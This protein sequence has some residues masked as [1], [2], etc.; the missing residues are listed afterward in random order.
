MKKSF[1]GALVV[2]LS[3]SS[4]QVGA[5]ESNNKGYLKNILDNN[6][7][8]INSAEVETKYDKGKNVPRFIEGDLSK[9]SI[10]DKDQALKYLNDNMDAFNLTKGSFKFV[11]EENEE[12][13][14]HFKFQYV[15]NGID[16][17]GSEIIIHTNKDNKVYAINGQAEPNIPNKD[18]SKDF[19]VS[20]EQAINSAYKS[21]GIKKESPINPKVNKYIKEVSGKW[22]AVYNM[23]LLKKLKPYDITI[24]AENGD[25]LE[26]NILA[27]NIHSEGEG[28]DLDGN[29]RKLNLD[30]ENGMYYLRDISNKGDVETSYGDKS[31]ELLTTLMSASSYEEYSKIIESIP[32]E[33]SNTNKFYNKDKAA[34][35]DAHSNLS[36]V[37][38]YYKDT[39]GREG[40]DD[41]GGKIKAVADIG[42][43]L[44]NAISM[45]VKKEG[46]TAYLI[47]GHTS[48]GEKNY[49]RALDVIAHEYTHSMIATTSK[50]YYSDE[51]GALNESFA[52]IFG[53]FIEGD[54]EDWDIGEDIY[55]NNNG[56]AIRCLDNPSKYGDA[57][58]IEEYYA[59]VVDN[60]GVH[61]NSTIHSKA[62]V[63]IIKEIGV[64][65]AEQ[66]Y[67]RALTKYLFSNSTFL[68][69]KYAVKQAAKDIV[70][71]K[72]EN[73]IEKAYDDVG[74]KEVEISAKVLAEPKVDISEDF[75]L[76][77]IGINVNSGN[78]DVN[79]IVDKDNAANRILIDEISIDK[80][81]NIKINN[82][83]DEKI[84]TRKEA[85]VK[86]LEFK[87]KKVGEYLYYITVQ[88]GNRH[89]R[90][91][92]DSLVIDNLNDIADVWNEN[93]EYK[94]EELVVYK[95]NVYTCLKDHS[96][97]SSWTP[98]V[99][100]S[101]WQKV[102]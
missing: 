3:L 4:I 85:Y 17:F 21:M 7:R 50:L 89:I 29:T 15:L 44:D 10:K 61:L 83:L 73:I 59:G 74:I 69:A 23:T 16:V 71:D 27:E 40:F 86:K 62:L 39:F 65:D 47:F 55:L 53:Y 96:S 87:N 28:I 20:E 1:I 67:Y 25:I 22:K 77:D 101:L 92:K 94:E 80:N 2:I 97:Q 41:K 45:P 51:S 42:K 81:G 102:F 93:K 70:G 60:G 34:T 49:A 68:D 35:I 72:Y 37:V 30:F 43:E 82:I 66:I 56:K 88:N 18:F 12:E 90:V 8:L 26:K 11:S 79:V 52:D 5:V 84:D 33:S 9:T 58:N 31:G 78:Y 13:F 64:H 57:Q 95:E 76:F 24:D 19:K 38:E 36:K 99:S 100:Y 63:N 98:D 91:V 32:V 14:N 75:E 46:Q 48:N 6:S 54:K